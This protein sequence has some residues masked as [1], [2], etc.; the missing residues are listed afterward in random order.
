MGLR[1]YGDKGLAFVPVL[2]RV[3]REPQIHD[4]IVGSRHLCHLLLPHAIFRLTFPVHARRFELGI[5]YQASLRQHRSWGDD[6]FRLEC[7]D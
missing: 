4:C 6:C 2:S 5:R 1:N 3:L 7:S